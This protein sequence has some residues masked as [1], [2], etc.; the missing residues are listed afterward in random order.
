MA[1]SR[2]VGRGPVEA[3]EA[4]GCK[5]QS[6]FMTSRH[7]ASRVSGARAQAFGSEQGGTFDI[8]QDL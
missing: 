7:M 1:V 3:V 6:S 8:N 5:G 4:R 2:G